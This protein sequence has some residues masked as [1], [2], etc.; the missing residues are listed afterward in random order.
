MDLAVPATVLVLFLSTLF[1]IL[2]A[3]ALLKSL[4]SGAFCGLLKALLFIAAFCAAAA[5]F[6]SHKT[7]SPVHF[8]NGRIYINLR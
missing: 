7:I 2:I 6:S 3:R 4:S 5:F 8:R 1:I